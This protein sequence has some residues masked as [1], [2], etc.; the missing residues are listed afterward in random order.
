MDQLITTR[1]VDAL[2]LPFL[3][4]ED[5]VESE[6]LLAQLICEQVDPV[7]TKIIKSKLRVP[8]NPAQGSER[9]QDALDIV[10]DLRAK[11]ISELRR[12]KESPNG[13]AINNLQH[14]V[15]VKAYSACNDYFRE[16]NPQR[17][18]TK[19]S[20]R[21]HLMQ[22]PDFALWKSVEHRWLCGLSAWQGAEQIPERL[23]DRLQRLTENPGVALL[24]I[25][26]NVDFQC[27]P[28]TDLMAAIFEFVRHPIELDRLVSITAQVWGVRDQP[29]ESFD[30][31]NNHLSRSLVDASVRVDAA[32][33]QRL[34]LEKLWKEV[35]DL[36]G[37]QRAALLLNLRDAGGASVI[38]FIPFLKIASRN[39]I[40][41]TLSMTDKQFA[42]LWD[43][44]PLDD[45]S[46]ARLLGV[47]RQQVI[48][49]RKTAR[50][51]LARR[52]KPPERNV[53]KPTE[54]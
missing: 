6:K 40:A 1:D 47:T 39:E 51:R 44:L 19:N 24:E 23:T 18:R 16:Q 13:K 52:M 35:C 22:H 30:D 45:T 41:E 15:A 49:L 2:L 25:I 53:Q 42:D 27:L 3:C 46:I 38:A 17:W 32:L 37:L 14:Y 12:L 34:Y 20:L 7:V 28:P 10:G 48:N 50:E 9:N 5:E 8:L 54:R 4:A 43:E 26:P 29:V 33:E 11:I 21:H 36:P 31:E